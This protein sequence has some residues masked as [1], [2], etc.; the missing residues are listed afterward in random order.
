MRD[1]RKRRLALVP[2]E[3]RENG[4]ALETTDRENSGTER[5]G[6][7]LPPEVEAEL[8][9]RLQSQTAVAPVEPAAAVEAPTRTAGESHGPRPPG[10]QD[11]LKQLGPIGVFLVY[12]IGK[13]KF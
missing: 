7:A 12:L 6:G 9:R 3:R 13:L 10:W 4:T 8:R 5:A 2:E 1:S 11:R